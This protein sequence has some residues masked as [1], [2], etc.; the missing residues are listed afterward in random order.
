[1][2]MP[3]GAGE[4]SSHPAAH[5]D[6]L[7]PCYNGGRY[8]REMLDSVR[9]QSHLEWRLW[10]RDDGSVDDT[11]DIIRE[12]AARDAR[13]IFLEDESRV[14]MGVVGAFGALMKRL[15]PSAYIMFADQD[16]V[17]LER[18]IHLTLAAMQRAEGIRPMP[19][20]VH[21]DLVV[22]DA[23]LHRLADSFWH[24]SGVDPE[25]T[26]LRRIVVQNVATGAAMMIN[27]ALRELIA[28]L[29]ENVVF[30]DWWCACVAS[31]VGQI[32]AVREPSIWYRQHGGNVVGARNR[33]L[34]NWRDVRTAASRALRGQ[35]AFTREFEATCRQAGELLSRFESRIGR[36]DREFLAA[37]S[38]MP[39][40]SFLRRK[41]EVM[42][43]RLRREYGF[44]RNLGVLLRA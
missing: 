10:I 5:V 35:R 40:R 20:L 32:I 23:H 30:H 24:Y 34:R 9:R 26:S 15:P 33:H 14:R 2:S 38:A 42:R 18:K 41:Y 25:P 8:L 37:F 11:R 22:V 19:T 6:I 3:G 36:D 27:A 4:A 43:L 39:D 28:P 7:L 21:T 12:F 29:N 17:W 16:D 44:L 1:M 31:A 13:I